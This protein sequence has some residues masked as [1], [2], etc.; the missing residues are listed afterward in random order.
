MGAFLVLGLLM[1]LY[2]FVSD[3]IANKKKEEKQIVETVKEEKEN[4]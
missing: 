1:A 2:N 4:A 3:K